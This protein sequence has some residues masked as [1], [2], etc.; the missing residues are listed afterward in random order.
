MPYQIEFTDKNN[1]SAV[2]VFDNTSST[3]TSLIFPGRNVTGYG[4][5]IAENF[6]HLLENFASPSEPVNP[7][8][9]QLWYDS[10][11][12]YLQLWDNTAWK[13]ASNIQK[14]PT[15]PSVETSKTGELWVDTTNQQ[16]RIF[17]GT[18]WLLV[19]PTESS[20]DGLR[21]GPATEQIQ[22]VDNAD[23]AILVFY[24]ADQPVIIVSKDSFTPKVTIPGFNTI[25]A[26]INVNVPADAVAQLDFEG[27]FIPKLYGTATTSDSLLISGTPVAAS[28]FL[29]SDVINTTE[30]RI[31]V[32]NNDGIVLGVDGNFTLAT[33]PTASRI[34]NSASGSSID[35]QTNRN[36]VPTTILRIIGNN[37]GINNPVPDESLDVV[38]NIKTS[39]VLLV[40]DATASTNFNNGSIRT[41]GG[42][43]ISK[44]LLIGDDLSV[45]GQIQ[46]SNVY[47]K[48]TDLYDCGTS[49]KR[50]KVV[51]AKTIIADEIQGV[52]TGNINGNANTATNLKNITT[53][54]MN[55]DVE[56][57]TTPVR[58]DGQIDGYAKVF[59]T[60]LSTN[61][62]KDKTEAT[63]STSS[64]YILTYR[65]GT[66]LLKSRRDTFVADLGVP[67]GAIFPFT[68][69]NVPAGYLLCDG[70]EVEIVRYPDLFNIIGTI[71]NGIT[72]LTGI[73]TYRLP[74]LR[75]RFPLG[76]DNM[77]NGIQV[78]KEGVGGSVAYVDAGGG[79]ASRVTDIK[80]QTLGGNA[81][82]STTTLSLSNLPEHTHTLRSA[83]QEY[84]VLAVTTS[85][86]PAATTG[87]GP[88][89]PGQA[90]YLKD[91]GGINK[92]SG[93]TLSAPVG[94]MN[95]Y[96]TINYIVRSGPP[97][98]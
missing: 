98:F 42:M 5:I 94:L 33:T 16:L 72:P 17:T 47:P 77:D 93:T 26:G 44:N 62:I 40:S 58:F 96:L 48:T 82:Q 89:A 84:N 14:S 10:A 64:D 3:D 69:N 27:G 78:P 90:Q 55:G 24:V 43:A 95:P 83:T 23:R 81:G 87:L 46:A 32:R 70:S 52:L 92:P 97:K 71:Y 18:R 4:K 22:D 85:I 29:R 73:G 6:L 30:Y 61:I 15:E 54:G 36:G 39:G 74:D 50:W 56:L 88:T 9:G 1:K 59:N 45:T 8:E 38:G 51:R 79:T 86:D 25:K 41:A 80:A 2:T 63:N 57:T 37:V 31:N 60:R 76:R 19:G 12:G 34:Y 35:L 91:S 65:E 49:T 13:A 20:K 68:G 53:F 75:G 7:V 66:G 67:I 21:Y 11:N 28:K